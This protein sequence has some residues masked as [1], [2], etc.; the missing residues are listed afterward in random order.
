M[1]QHSPRIS[2]VSIF[3]GGEHALLTKY[4]PPQNL[5]G[6]KHLYSYRERRIPVVGAALQTSKGEAT[7]R[8][9]M[10]WVGRLPI[11]LGF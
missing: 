9:C 10:G 7:S 3:S 6:Q 4:I 11:S 2:R 8:T 1:A 5:S